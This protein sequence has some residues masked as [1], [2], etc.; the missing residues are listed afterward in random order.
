M[1]VICEDLEALTTVRARQFYSL[2]VIKYR[3]YVWLYHILS[4][5]YWKCYLHSSV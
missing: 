5:S 2:I 4:H 1:G 3:Y